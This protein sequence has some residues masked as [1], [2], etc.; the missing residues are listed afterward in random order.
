M[1]ITT[2]SGAL[3]LISALALGGCSGAG[4]PANPGLNEGRFAPCPDSPNCVSSQASAESQRVEPLRY[5]GDAVQAQSRLLMALN[6]MQRVRI[7]RTDEGYIHAVFRSAL[8][9]FEDDVEFHFDSTGAIQVRSASRVGYSDFGVNRQRVED[10]RTR[11][12][13]TAGA[14]P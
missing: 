3:T 5:N 14:T 10:I 8:L 4:Q 13:A 2:W 12:A 11:F 6:G 9:G 1:A 7:E